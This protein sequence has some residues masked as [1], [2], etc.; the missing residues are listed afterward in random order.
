MHN[1]EG[2]SLKDVAR[3]LFDYDLWILYLIGLTTFIAPGTVTA[4]FTL[5]LKSL[6]FSTFQTNLLTI[7][8]SVLFIIVSRHVIRWRSGC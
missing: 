8:A 5:T 7:P 6:G 3:S 4:Y 1:R 2:L